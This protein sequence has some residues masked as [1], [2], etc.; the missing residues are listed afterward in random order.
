MIDD[1]EL[2]LDFFRSDN[3]IEQ[4]LSK[5]YQV[6]MGVENIINNRSSKALFTRLAHFSFIN[7]SFELK[8]IDHRTMKNFQRKSKH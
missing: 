7:Q 2:R 6:T 1:L 4:R 3:K 8:K 5:L